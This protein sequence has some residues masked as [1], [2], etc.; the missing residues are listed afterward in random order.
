MV[1]STKKIKTKLGECDVAVQTYVSEL[2]LEL[3]ALKAELRKI[4]KQFAKLNA[5]HLSQKALIATYE[6]Q[7]AGKPER[8]SAEPAKEKEKESRSLLDPPIFADI[9]RREDDE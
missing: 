7:L 8:E 9:D 3:K 2:E 5:E 1:R 6:K 4:Q